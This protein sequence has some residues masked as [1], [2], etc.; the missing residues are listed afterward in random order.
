[1][2]GERT[3]VAALPQELR[4]AAA[5]ILPGD[6]FDFVDGGA[7]DER[8]AR[9]NVERLSRYTFAPRVMARSAAPVT[10][11]TVLGVELAVPIVVAPMGM[12]RLIHPEGERASAAAARRAGAGFVVAT[13]SSIA[14]EDVAPVAGSARW[15]Q[16]YLMRDRGLSRD[17]VQRAL[18]AGY[19]GVFLTADVPV[20]GDRPRDRRARFR[21]PDG[22]R[23]ANFEAYGSVDA[24]HHRYVQDIEPDLGWDDVSWL[25]GL[26]G[27][28]PLVVKGVL[29][30]DDARRS[31]EHGA[32]GLVVSNHGG[33][34]LG[35][36]RA[37]IDVLTAVVDEVAARACVLFDGGIRSASDIAV[38]VGSGAAAV[39]L[40]RPVLWSLALAGEDGVQALLSR[41]SED[42]IRTMTLLGAPRLSD[43]RDVVVHPQ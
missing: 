39:L 41:L 28:A 20:V 40:G 7:E 24:G 16:L 33:R 18:D 42:L 8:T 4:G 32:A 12:Q 3:G 37:S 22:L 1:M 31:V 29:R 5:A 43:L 34:Q 30:P 26:C 6:V 25:A 19:R 10:S 27:D 13:G 38:A 17:L 35:R 9:A 21:P 11:T 14:M 23:N 2:T 15:F 36:A